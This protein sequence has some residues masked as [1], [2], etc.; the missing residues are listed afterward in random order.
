MYLSATRLPDFPAWQNY[1]VLIRGITQN[2]QLSLKRGRSQL[3]PGNPPDLRSSAVMVQIAEARVLFSFGS[4][5]SAV[6]TDWMMT[7]TCEIVLE[8]GLSVC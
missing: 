2:F 3:I 1:G 5:S 7:Q 4:A 6:R 8:S